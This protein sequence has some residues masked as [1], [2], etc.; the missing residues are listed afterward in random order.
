MRQKNSF[1]DEIKRHCREYKKGP[2]LDLKI[3]NIFSELLKLN[4]H[5]LGYSFKNNFQ[6]L[7]FI[8]IFI[9]NKLKGKVKI[10]MF[11]YNSN[12]LCE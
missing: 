6:K 9:I 7:L 10:I 2:F 3:E 4:I 1:L 8:S 12:A 11:I 5:F